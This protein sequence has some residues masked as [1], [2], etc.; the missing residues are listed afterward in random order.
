[1]KKNFLFLVLALSIMVAGCKKKDLPEPKEET[2]TTTPTIT[3]QFYFKATIDGKE[4]IIQDGKD[5]YGSGALSTGNYTSA[6]KLEEQWTTLRKY[7][8]TGSN[9]SVGMR[10][11]FSS[12]PDCPQQFSMITIGTTS[13]SLNE[14]DGAIIMYEDENEKA[15]YSYHGDQA[16]NTFEVTEYIDNAGGTSNKII[17]AKFT[18]KLYSEDGNSSIT[19]TNG[20]IRGRIFYCL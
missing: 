17:K 5:G 19:L 10:K 7:T 13:Y 16:G 14:S 4:V 11:L 20:E 9:I 15:W 18:A 6:G 2:P 8:S 3:S 12:T 1:M